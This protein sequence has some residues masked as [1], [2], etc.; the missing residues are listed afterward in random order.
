MSLENITRMSRIFY[1]A[2]DNVLV[3]VVGNNWAENETAATFSRLYQNIN[4]NLLRR[5]PIKKQNYYRLCISTSYNHCIH[6]VLSKYFL[7]HFLAQNLNFNV[8]M[9]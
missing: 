2:K 7:T 6:S 8:V 5:K 4:N 9:S 3:L 1:F